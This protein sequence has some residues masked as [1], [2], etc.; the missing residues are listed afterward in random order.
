MT[1][2]RE[3]GEFLEEHLQF[4]WIPNSY[5]ALCEDWLWTGRIIEAMRERGYHISAHD[6][7]TCVMFEQYIEEGWFSSSD[8]EVREVISPRTVALAAAK[9]L[10]MEVSDDGK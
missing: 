1:S 6:A 3:V 8:W 7:A 5:A 9:A 2:D 10:G 4:S